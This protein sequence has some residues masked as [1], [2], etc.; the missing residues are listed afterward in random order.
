MLFVIRNGTRYH[1]NNLN[2]SIFSVFYHPC[3]P[4]L[5]TAT[6]RQIHSNVLD[7]LEESGLY[8]PAGSFDAK[9]RDLVIRGSDGQPLTIFELERQIEKTVNAISKKGEL[10]NEIVTAVDSEPRQKV[11][12]LM[13]LSLKTLIGYTPGEHCRFTVNLQNIKIFKLRVR[14]H[15]PYYMFTKINFLYSQKLCTLIPNRNVSAFELDPINYK[16]NL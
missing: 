4:K 3:D 8:I 9:S 16:I 5:N 14:E 15:K 13:M 6:D 1:S 7:K 12:T 2:N 11:P 10:R